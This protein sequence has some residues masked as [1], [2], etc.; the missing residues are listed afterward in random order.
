M[1]YSF[2]INLIFMKGIKIEQYTK[3]DIMFS[4]VDEIATV[5]SIIMKHKRLCVTEF[6]FHTST[7]SN[8]VIEGVVNGET[9]SS[10]CISSIKDELIR[11]T[12]WKAS[13]DHLVTIP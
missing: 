12:K 13:T 9:S 2:R 10:S 6:N 5:M 8:C 4:E 3:Q 7:I 1:R 11:T